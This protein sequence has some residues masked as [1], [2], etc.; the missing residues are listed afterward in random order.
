[1]AESFKRRLQLL[2]RQ[3]QQ[4]ENSLTYSCDA[5][6]TVLPKTGDEP[7][8]RVES[9]DGDGSPL[10]QAQSQKRPCGASHIVEVVPPAPLNPLALA[11]N[12]HG[13]LGN[14]CGLCTYVLLRTYVI[15]S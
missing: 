8:W 5:S 15:D 10:L 14:G 11:L 4:V 2:R 13:N 12:A 3:L 9:Q 6:K 7:F 1:M